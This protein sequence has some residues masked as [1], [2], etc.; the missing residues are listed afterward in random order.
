MIGKEFDLLIAC[1]ICGA[2][3]LEVGC[4]LLTMCLVFSYCCKTNLR[5]F[6]CFKK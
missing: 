1:I 6:F 4:L 2:R 3:K 5:Y